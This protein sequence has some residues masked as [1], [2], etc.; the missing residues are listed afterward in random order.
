M[1]IIYK[2]N[3]KKK[4]K[5]KTSPMDVLDDPQDWENPND[6]DEIDAVAPANDAVLEGPY[7]YDS[8]DE[9]ILE[10]AEQQGY[11]YDNDR[12]GTPL[13]DLKTPIA[14]LKKSNGPAS[15]NVFFLPSNDI[16]RHGLLKLCVNCSEDQCVDL[17]SKK[18]LVDAV[19]I[20]KTEIDNVCHDAST[21]STKLK[22]RMIN[23]DSGLNEFKYGDTGQIVIP[24]S[25]RIETFMAVDQ[26]DTRL[27]EFIAKKPTTEL[28]W[29]AFLTLVKYCLTQSRDARELARLYSTAVSR[30]CFLFP[31]NTQELFA[32]SAQNAFDLVELIR[33]QIT[34]DYQLQIG[35]LTLLA[36]FARLGFTEAVHALI[37]HG[38]NI[39]EI[40]QELPPITW[41]VKDYLRENNFPEKQEKLYR[42]IVLLL[43]RGANIDEKELYHVNNPTPIHVAIAGGNIRLVKLLLPYTLPTVIDFTNHAFLS[44]RANVV[45]YLMMKKQPKVKLEGMF[46]NLVLIG[47]E[48]N[49]LYEQLKDIGT[50]DINYLGGSHEGTAV[51]LAARKNN[52]NLIKILINLKADIN[53]GINNYPLHEAAKHGFLD[54]VQYLFSLNN[55]NLFSTD[56]LGQ[57]ALSLS[58]SGSSTSATKIIMYKLFLAKSPETLVQVDLNFNTILHKA[59]E[60]RDKELVNYIVLN[61]VPQRYQG[62]VVTQAKET[63]LQLAVRLE[64]EDIADLLRGV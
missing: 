64:E 58:I 47:H 56:N 23:V 1:H 37:D 52:L 46:Y 51:T 9:E 63:P 54:I 27:I 57:S 11:Y 28:R 24:P 20:L 4:E 49:V 33:Q 44:G 8:A 19:A 59:V 3:T 48:D 22:K 35:G 5:L 42:T 62:E 17:Q 18:Q 2:G 41:C 61:P 38:A 31:T 12:V 60:T 53:K 6:F 13:E 7:A 16:K 32:V 30:K 39:N 45:Q 40:S 25:L 55:L 21:F 34:L 10:P 29:K 14:F 43:K 26:G 15:E 50:A 36:C